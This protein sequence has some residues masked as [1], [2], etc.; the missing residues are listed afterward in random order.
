MKY[1][2]EVGPR[3]THSLAPDYITNLYSCP[4]DTSEAWLIHMF[5]VFLEMKEAEVLKE[6]QDTT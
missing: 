4:M 5:S 6:C 2:Q 3:V 1:R